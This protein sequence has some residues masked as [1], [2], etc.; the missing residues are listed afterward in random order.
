MY[1]FILKHNTIDFDLLNSL[2]AYIDI[3]SFAR[4]SKQK[5]PPKFSFGTVS[6]PLIITVKITDNFRSTET[7]DNVDRRRQR[8][9]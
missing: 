5:K 3:K 4:K 1:H 2:S 7:S 6:M 8:E 9:V